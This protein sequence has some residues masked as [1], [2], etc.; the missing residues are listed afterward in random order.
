MSNRTLYG[1]QAVIEGVMI[2]GR[3][4][5][6]VT[7]RKA[8]GDIVR[9]AI[10]L[11]SWSKNRA[12]QL[13]LARGVL[14]LLETLI[15]GMKALTFSANEAVEDPDDPSGSSESGSQAISTG[16]MV[17]MIVIALAIGILVFFM[18]PLFASRGVESLIESAVVANIVEGLIRLVLFL[19]YIWL[20]GWMSDI[21]RVFGYHGAEHMVVAAHEAGA[22][23][24]VVSVRRFSTAHPRCGTA[25]L[26]TVV[27]VSI[28]LFMAIPREPFWLLFT[29]RLIL[30]PPIAAIS[31]ELIRFAGTHSEMAVVRFLSSPNLLLQKMTTRQPDDGMIEVAIDAMNYA[32]ALDGAPEAS[33]DLDSSLHSE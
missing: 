30:I 25:F 13:P 32:Q 26:L 8:S 7:V 21:K 10:P 31:Y 11:E 1:G 27:L 15:M 6:A 33:A 9:H 14:V 5:A 2:R 29:S 24:D 16:G 19:G 28:L 12:R 20:I 4:Q 22:P 17:A 23:L 3:T 18:I